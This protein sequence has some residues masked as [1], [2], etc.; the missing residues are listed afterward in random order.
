[1]C[2]DDP[3][4]QF[5]DLLIQAAD[6]LYQKQRFSK[7]LPKVP[8][9][10]DNCKTAIKERKEAQQKF[11]FYFLYNPTLSNVQNFKLLRAKARHAVKQQK[12]N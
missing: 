8:W 4:G 6:K 3:A 2:A 10:N 9:F 12:R 7:K 11:I 5:T 1:M